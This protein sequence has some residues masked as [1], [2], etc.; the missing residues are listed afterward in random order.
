MN[1]YGSKLNPDEAIQ[2]IEICH[3]PYH[4][5]LHKTIDIVLEKY[6]NCV[7]SACH[8][9]PPNDHLERPLADIILGDLHHNTLDRNLGNRLQEH[10]VGLGYSAV[11]NLP[12]AGGYITKKYG[13]MNSRV[14]TVQIE[15][16]RK[17]Y[18]DNGLC[19]NDEGLRQSR[20]YFKVFYL[21][22]DQN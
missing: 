14:Q 11:W 8:S 17:L 18:M 6:K 5:A 2:R 15:I 19:I 9:M 4:D 12:Y 3:K 7:L 16:N 10:I 21:F 22:E 13:R 1:I 20:P